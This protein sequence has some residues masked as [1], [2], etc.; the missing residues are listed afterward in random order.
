M[1]LVPPIPCQPNAALSIS[2]LW[3]HCHAGD[4]IRLW[5]PKTV[6]TFCSTQGVLIPLNQEDVELIEG[7]SLNSLQPSTR[8][9]YGAGLLAFHIFCDSKKMDKDLRA[10]VNLAIL[11]SFVARMAG[12]YST[13]TISG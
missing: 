9:S 11:Q 1:F 8:A 4:R 5:K 6:R 10:P 2:N 13:L 3:P 7:V 12:I